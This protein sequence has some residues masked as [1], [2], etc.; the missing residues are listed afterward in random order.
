MS[1]GAFFVSGL[2]VQGHEL[3]DA[4]RLWQMGQ[5]GRPKG[6]EPVSWRCEYTVSTPSD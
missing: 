6:K 2:A 3:P 1:G 4:G 5:K